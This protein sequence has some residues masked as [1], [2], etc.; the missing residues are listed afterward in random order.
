MDN[1]EKKE[2]LREMFENSKVSVI[3][4]SAGTGKTTLMNHISNFFNEKKKLYLAQTNTAV[5]NMRRR[6]NTQDSNTKFMTISKYLRSSDIIEYFDIVFIDESS[7]VNNK[8]MSEILK[9]DNFE[10]L[11]LVGDVYQIESIEFGNW[12]SL[13]NSFLPQTSVVRLNAPYRTSDRNLQ[14]FWDAVRKDD[15][16]STTKNHKLISEISARNGYSRP[17]DETVFS[18]DFLDEII[19]CLNYDG[20]YGINNINTLIQQNNKQPSVLWGVQTYKVGDPI[21]FN[22]SIVSNVLYNNLKGW[23]VKIDKNDE[24]KIVFDIK[25]DKQLDGNIP[26]GERF[27]FLGNTN[28]GKSIIQLEIIRRYDES[29]E[30]DVIPFQVAY[31]LSVHKAQ[32]LE[33]DSVKLIITDE[34]DEQV[35]HSV[36]YTAITRAKQNLRIYWSP[37]VENKILSNMQPRKVSAKDIH[38]LR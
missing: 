16:D 15:S 33:F 34:V 9:R 24:F 38:F 36:F 25:L 20:L 12:F 18:K 5:E 2:A 21:L 35:T 37:E 27:R 31:A 29:Q 30:N 26:I 17:L 14:I 28:D 13:A 8:N 32:G 11:V 10:M 22:D 19:L 7:T 4:G 3:Y 1:A 23:I 6:I